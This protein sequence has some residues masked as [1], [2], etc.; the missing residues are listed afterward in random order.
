[1]IQEEINMN[2][3]IAHKH[4]YDYCG[5]HISIYPTQRE[6]EIWEKDK[7]LAR[8]LKKE[9]E[10]ADYVIVTGTAHGWLSK[11]SRAIY[12]NETFDKLWH[13]LAYEHCTPEA[14]I[15]NHKLIK[16]R[17]KAEFEKKMQEE[18]EFI[19]KQLKVRE[20]IESLRK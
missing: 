14:K 4:G 7:A 17:L 8:K 19:E 15:E 18:D 1:M 5:P 13:V 6:V 11:G 2:E 9:Y 20:W 3:Y 10:G 12:G 16:E